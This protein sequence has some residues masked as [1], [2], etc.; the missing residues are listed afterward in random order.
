MLLKELVSVA[1]TY[2]IVCMYNSIRMYHTYVSYV[3][4][5]LCMYVCMHACIY[6]YIYLS[7]YLYIYIYI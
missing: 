3:C 7:I 2:G 6:I 4:M 5:Y 1:A